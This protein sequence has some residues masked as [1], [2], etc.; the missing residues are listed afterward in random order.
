MINDL[1]N[2]GVAPIE[3]S[4]LQ[5]MYAQEFKP[6]AFNLEDRTKR[7]LGDLVYVRFVA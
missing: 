4:S 7:L 3:I 2:I 6:T 5:H 1:P